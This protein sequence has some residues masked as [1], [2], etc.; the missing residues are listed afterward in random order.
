MQATATS[1]TE[2]IQSYIDALSGRPKTSD[3]ISRFVSDP[4]LKEHIAQTE[5]AFPDYELSAQQMV[6]QDDLVAMRG[7]FR[8]VHRGVFAGIEPTGKEVSGELMIFYRIEEGR[9]VQHWMQIDMMA[10]V[11]Q[12]RG[13]A[14]VSGAQA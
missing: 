9:I 4:V 13:D 14:G 11:A 5:A 12:L 1:G 2:F 8:G 6:A 10:L 7:T 3:V